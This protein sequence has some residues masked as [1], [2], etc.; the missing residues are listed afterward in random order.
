MRYSSGVFP[1]FRKQNILL[2][3]RKS[4]E[5]VT[6]AEMC[7][8]LNAYGKYTRQEIL[9]EDPTPLLFWRNRSEGPH[10]W[11]F[12]RSL[13]TLCKKFANWIDSVTRKLTQDLM[14]V[15]YLIDFFQHKPKRSKKSIHNAILWSK[16]ECETEIVYR[17]NVAL[18]FL[19][20]KTK[21]QSLAGN[22]TWQE[23]R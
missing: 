9:A 17:V 1:P 13:F 4:S 11:D 20:R 6:G 21:L 15:C 14:K 18:D 23:S 2:E 10:G 5:I 12:T 8:K 16:S 19:V 3:F 7:H 22:H